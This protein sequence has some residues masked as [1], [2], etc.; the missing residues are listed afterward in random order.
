MSMAE[1][2]FLRMSTAPDGSVICVIDPR[3]IGPDPAAFGIALVDAVRH[4]AKAYAQA[5]GVTE[6]HALERIWWGFEAE[7]GSPTD[8]P[9][10][11]S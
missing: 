11:V 3:G 7:R 8:D 4:G 9:R 1:G 10:Q 5:V 2:E 6:Q